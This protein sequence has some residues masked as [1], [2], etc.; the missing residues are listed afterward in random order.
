MKFSDIMIYYNYKMT[1]V[2]R[3]L[4]VGRQTVERWKKAG[5]I[6]FEKQCVL[7]ILTDG[8]LVAERP[9][10]QQGAQLMEVYPLTTYYGVIIVA[11]IVLMLCMHFM[12][13]QY[14]STAYIRNVVWLVSIT[15]SR[16]YE[17]VWLHRRIVL[18]MLCW[19]NV[20]LVI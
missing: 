7:E 16:I 10:Q 6:P 12:G 2:A 3:A 20:C 17:E 1:N 15:A 11:A 9:Q 8:K 14:V 13:K 19:F 5:K 4:H 18:C